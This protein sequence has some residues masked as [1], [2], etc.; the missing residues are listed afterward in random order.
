MSVS[1]DQA[2]RIAD[3]IVQVLGP[4]CALIDIA[5]SVRRRVSVVKDIEVVA[6]PKKETKGEDLFGNGEQMLSRDFVEALAGITRLIIKGNVQGRYMQIVL[7][8]CELTLDLFLPVEEDYYRQLAIRTGNAEYS[9]KVIAQGWR[10]KGFVGSDHG[11][12]READCIPKRNDKGEIVGWKCIRL[13]G[14][15]P[16]AWKAEEEFF[17]WLGV[18]YIEPQ[19]RDMRQTINEAQ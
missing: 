11:L 6:L 2:K 16:P 17:Q 10:R 18:R 7:V 1:F 15:L 9:Q 19:L 14:E 5:G 12:R 4:H 3:R 13:D 8:K